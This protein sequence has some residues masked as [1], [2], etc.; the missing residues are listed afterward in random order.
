MVKSQMEHSVAYHLAFGDLSNMPKCDCPDWLQ[1]CLPCKHLLTIFQHVPGWEWTCLP[2]KYRESPML[3][4]DDQVMQL[5]NPTEED[6][7]KEDLSKPSY[8]PVESESDFVPPLPLPIKQRT[9]RSQATKCREVRQQLRS[10]TFLV[11]DEEAL[12]NLHTTLSSALV[13][14]QQFVSAEDGIAL[15]NKS[16]TNKNVQHSHSKSS[17]LPRANS[18][19]RRKEKRHKY[20]GRVGEVAEIMRKTYNVQSVPERAEPVPNHILNKH[21]GVNLPEEQSS[22]EEEITQPSAAKKMKL[23]NN[24]DTPSNGSNSVTLL[25][26]DAPDPQTWVTF[27]NANSD[28][29]FSLYEASKQNITDPQGWLTDSEIH[30]AQQ[31]LKAQF[32]HTDG[33]N[34]PA[35][36]KGDLVTPAVSEFVQVI[37]TGLHCSSFSRF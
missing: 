35:I 23:D 12:N 22:A 5:T 30:A 24:A 18:L 10:M 15:E 20:S 31:L 4:L 2:S 7:S 8:T 13:N 3:L 17:N 19:P 33:L 27:N 25:E 32:P 1:T 26:D 29:E 21:A 28:L 6:T 11:H 9:P 16:Y 37:N 34:D 36:L 14:L